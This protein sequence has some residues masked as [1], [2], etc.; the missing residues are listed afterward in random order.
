MPSTSWLVRTQNIPSLMWELRI[1]ISASSFSK[2]L[3]LASVVHMHMH[4][5]LF[6]QDLNEK[7]SADFQR[8]NRSFSFSLLW[9]TILLLSVLFYKYIYFFFSVLVFLKPAMCLFNLERLVGSAWAQ[10]LSR[11]GVGGIHWALLIHCFSVREHRTACCSMP[12]YLCFIYFVWFSSC[13]RW[14]G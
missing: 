10:P 7:P 3:Y 14:V 12:E 8:V 9:K 6:S 4:R 13:L 11:Q 1:I 2:V 5:S